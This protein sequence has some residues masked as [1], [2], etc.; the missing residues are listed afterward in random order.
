MDINSL[1]QLATPENAAIVSTIGW[2]LCEI[3]ARIPVKAN[4]TSQAVKNGALF[5]LKRLFRIE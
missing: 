3:I 5:V 4:T 2:V 1:K